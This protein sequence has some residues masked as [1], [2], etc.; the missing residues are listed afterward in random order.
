[1]RVVAASGAF[2]VAFDPVVIEGEGYI[3]G[4]VVENLGV[5]GLQ[6][7]FERHAQDDNLADRLPDVLILS[8]AGLIPA[9]PPSWNK[10]SVVQMAMRA[11]QTSYFAM[12]RWI[13]DFYT[14]G[15][16]DRAG[17]GE[18]EQPFEVT[19]GRLWPEVPDSLRNHPVRI[20][21]FSPSSPAERSRFSGHEAL[22]DAV[23][24]LDTLKELKPAE[25]D[26]AYWVGARL[27]QSYLGELCTAAETVCAPVELGPAP[28]L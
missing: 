22:L 10:P 12:H 2:P 13:Y 17:S 14:D 18:L 3:D 4:G 8:D 1:L 24:A 6:Q 26:A 5:A 11:Q 9:A 15:D 27:A 25:V 19:A 28:K 21:V 7:Y 16:Y 20:F 23:S